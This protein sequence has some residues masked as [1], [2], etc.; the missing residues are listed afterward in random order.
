MTGRK[1]YHGFDVVIENCTGCTSCVRVCPTEAMRVRNGKVEIDATRCID[2]GNC[3]SACKYDVLVPRPD[4]LEKIKEFTYRVAI[5]TSAFAGQFSENISYKEVLAA[6]K[7]LGFDLVIE[8]S[9]VT[10]FMV[11]LIREYVRENKH[12]RPILSSNC[13]AVVRLIQVRFPSLLPNLLLMESPMGILAQYY[14]QKISKEQGLQAHEIGI[15]NIIPCIAELTA[16]HEPEGARQKLY[17]GAFSI[18]T[19]YNEV[20]QI[21]KTGEKLDTDFVSY[22][23]GLSW[24]LSGVEADL[25]DCD[26]IRTLSVN[27]I[28]N[29]KDVLSKVE[30]H[31]LDQYDYIVVRNCK[32]GCVGGVLNVEN[33]FVAMSRIKKLTKQAEKVKYDD[34][35][36]SEMDKN[37]DFSVDP[38]YPRSMM[39]L[40][41]DIKLALIKM[42]KLNEILT[43]L[44]G[45]NCSACGSPNC[46]SL[47]EDIVQDRATLDDCIILLK[48][49]KDEEK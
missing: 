38:I 4:P 29:V 9:M 27:G 16:T 48:Q 36:V 18:K 24:T 7:K 15:F 3:V 35:E 6:V 47:A 17:D 19:I 46:Y 5:V 41:P 14:R 12:I 34:R 8:E 11:R 28:E 45:L 32:N 10:G 42:K 31:Y 13:P 49:I 30:D 26:D 44:P 25:V 43:Q 37:G 1:Y 23:S 22:D 2:C 39:K 20:K 33:P 40:D 21:L